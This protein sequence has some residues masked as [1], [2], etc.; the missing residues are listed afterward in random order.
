[1]LRCIIDSIGDLIFIK[2][3]NGVYQACNKAAEEFFGLP[4]SEQI[5]K[6]D[7]DFFEPD[8]AETIR[9]HDQQIL[10]SGKES[11]FEEWVTYQDGSSNFLI[12]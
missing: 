2:D 5:G 10:A 4:E 11:R 12:P 8:I 3:M 7:F 1:L 6:T 9:E